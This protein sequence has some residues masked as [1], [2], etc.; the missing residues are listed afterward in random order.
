MKY[1]IKNRLN[2]IPKYS[3]KF[4]IKKDSNNF[5][6]TVKKSIF[7]LFSIQAIKGLSSLTL[8]K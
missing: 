4:L 3:N 7:S 6:L 1:F 8:P 5:I 2:F